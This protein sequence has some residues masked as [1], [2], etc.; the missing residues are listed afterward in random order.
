[1]KA[2]SRLQEIESL[3]RSLMNKYPE[4]VRAFLHFLNTVVKEKGLSV[5]EKELIAL[6]LGIATG[7]EWCITLHTKKALE[8]GATEE[9]IIEAAFVAVLM[10]GGPALMHMIPLMRVVREFKGD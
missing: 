2:E 1:M 10:A 8:A 9:Q 3:L 5:K 7:C 6:A 4:E